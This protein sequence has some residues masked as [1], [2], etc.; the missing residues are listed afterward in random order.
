M[1]HGD[2]LRATCRPMPFCLMPRQYRCNFAFEAICCA[3]FATSLGGALRVRILA[4]AACRHCFFMRCTRWR[5]ISLPHTLT[6]SIWPR[7]RVTLATRRARDLRFDGRAFLRQPDD[8]EGWARC[9]LAPCKILAT[10]CDIQ[11]QTCR[12]LFLHISRAQMPFFFFT[13]RGRPSEARQKEEPP[14][15]RPWFRFTGLPLL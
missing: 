9:S 8:D 11:M 2:T 1:F 14:V 13:P 12:G 10:K 5:A 3:G 7:Y 4:G 15:R 6:Q